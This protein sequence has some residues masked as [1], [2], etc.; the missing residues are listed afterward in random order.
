MRV[1]SGLILGAV[2]SAAAVGLAGSGKDRDSSGFE[3]SQQEKRY[4]YFRERQQQ[5]DVQS[6]RRQQEK[7]RADK[8]YR[9][10]PC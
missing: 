4:D 7:D 2:L 6:I 3:R 1:L 9:N 8:T 10:K 5:Q